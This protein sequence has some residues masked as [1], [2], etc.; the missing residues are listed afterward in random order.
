MYTSL[1]RQGFSKIDMS[2][3]FFRC[4]TIVYFLTKRFGEGSSDFSEEKRGSTTAST[5]STFMDNRNFSRFARIASLLNMTKV[6]III[7]AGSGL[8]ASYSELH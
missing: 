4:R 7:I 1:L 3:L 6:R 8:V 2:S 5:T